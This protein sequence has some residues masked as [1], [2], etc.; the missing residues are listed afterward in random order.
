VAAGEA[1]VVL[2][3]PLAFVH[4]AALV[5]VVAAPHGQTALLMLAVVE[6]DMTMA[7][8]TV[9]VALAVQAVVVRALV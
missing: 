3:R 2:G 7:A 4:I 5:M 8:T 9:T 1:L 6:V